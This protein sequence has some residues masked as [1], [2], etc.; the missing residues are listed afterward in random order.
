MR[1][2]GTSVIIAGLI[3]GPAFAWGPE[4]HSVIAAIAEQSLSRPTLV[5]IRVMLEPGQ[6]LSSVASWAD[7]VRRARPWTANWHF[8]DMPV[9][10]ASYD[11]ERDCPKDD[12]VVEQINVQLKILRD[13]KQPLPKRQEALRWVVHFVGDIHQPLH[14]ADNHDRGGN[15]VLVR[16]DGRPQKLHAVWDSG[17][18]DAAADDHGDYAARL[19][20]TIT[21]AE[22]QTWTQ[23]LDPA[24]WANE[25]HALAKSEIYDPLGLTGHPGVPP[26]VIDLPDTYGTDKL[27]VVETQ[28]KRGGVRLA[29]VL[30]QAFSRP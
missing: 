7:E 4:G 12:C 3:A 17:I 21:L 13:A 27:P 29:A 6:S 14:D 18:I 22:R 25:S 19:R 15:D 9:T 28:L 23:S 5:K 16:F 24:L 10:A 30:E 1:L 2:F 20:G 26:K 8:V 11:H